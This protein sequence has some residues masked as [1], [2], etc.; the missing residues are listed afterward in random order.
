MKCSKCLYDWISRKQN[1]KSCPRCKTRLDISTPLPPKLSGSN[2][3]T[4]LNSSDN[5]KQTEEAGDLFMLKE[6]DED[7]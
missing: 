5:Q 6:D 2:S 3:I 1:P 4:S 7:D